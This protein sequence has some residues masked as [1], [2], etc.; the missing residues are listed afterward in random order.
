MKT[1]LIQ[2]A[3][4]NDNPN[5]NGIDS[6]LSFDYMGSSEFEWGALRNSL[7]E[8]RNRS[9]EYTF[10][11]VP[12]KDK[13][14]TVYCLEGVKSEVKQYLDELSE[15]KMRLKEFS[16]FDKYI[17]NDGYFKDR[18]DFWWD[19]QNN[20]M[21]WKKTQILNLKLKKKSISDMDVI[22]D[23]LENK[24]DVIKFL[25]QTIEHNNKYS[26]GL[27]KIQNISDD[28]LKIEKLVEVVS[29]QSIQIKHLTLLLLCYVQGYD[30]D[31][32]VTHLLNKMGRGEEALKQMIKNKF[33]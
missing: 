16:A 5:K 20:V 10:L 29:N 23:L 30:F 12:I 14:I 24:G 4:F 6:I 2:R 17:K 13:V 19:I 22:F 11:D 31:V 1:Y 25:L 33:K 32:D 7:K 8:I 27:R 9:N 15:N 26:N 21:F 28:S 18:V 3:R